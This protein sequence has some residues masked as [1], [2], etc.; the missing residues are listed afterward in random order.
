L[1]PDGRRSD[2]IINFAVVLLKS[3]IQLFWSRYVVLLL[4]CHSS[5][6]ISGSRF[7]T[8]NCRNCSFSRGWETGQ[9]RFKA[10][11]EYKRM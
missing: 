11:A 4:S 10:S 7:S 3:V 9:Q 8:K 1:A 2:F 6:Y 5:C